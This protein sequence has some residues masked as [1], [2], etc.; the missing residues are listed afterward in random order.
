M[1]G[2]TFSHDRLLEDQR[3]PSRNGDQSPK[4][5]CGCPCGGGM[6]IGHTRSSLTS[7][8]HLSMYNCIYLSIYIYIPVDPPAGSG[9][10]TKL[11][12]SKNNYS[13][14]YCQ[15]FCHASIP[16]RVDKDKDPLPHSSKHWTK[17]NQ[18]KP[19][20][21]QKKINYFASHLLFHRF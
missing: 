4:T 1:W 7:W 18:K 9:T 12:I 5:V 2:T 8:N 10:T 11:E 19:R 16:S 17:K 21:N 13:T 14:N 15:K 3:P 6:K 20:L